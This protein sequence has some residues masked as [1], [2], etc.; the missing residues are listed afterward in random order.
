MTAVLEES[1]VAQLPHLG[2]HGTHAAAAAG[3]LLE[4][5]SEAIFE[6]AQPTLDMGGA[7]C[8]CGRS[9][10]A[11]HRERLPL[12]QH[13]GLRRELWLTPRSLSAEQVAS[14]WEP[15][16]LMLV[17]SAVTDLLH[18][19]PPLSEPAAARRAASA[20]ESGGV[21]EA[22]SV[23]A[24]SADG[25]ASLLAPADQADTPPSPGTSGRLAQA[26][27]LLDRVIASA[28]RLLRMSRRRPSSRVTRR[29]HPLAAVSPRADETE[30][31]AAPR[32]PPRRE[33]A[34]GAF[35]RLHAQPASLARLIQAVRARSSARSGT[36][37]TARPSWLSAS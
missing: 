27:I 5:V 17:P 2:E 1:L 23:A 30:P 16:A 13:M 32:R 21:E 31:A 20:S 28:M 11:A 14:L 36:A 15:P 37:R 18:R 34:R 29:L 33:S 3:V 8:G 24:P 4:A 12:P 6:A 22:C 35:C 19:F 26:A 9:L 25:T 7:L 10:R